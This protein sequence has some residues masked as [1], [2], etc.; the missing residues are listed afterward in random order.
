MAD[1]LAVRACADH[2]IPV[3][4]TSFDSAKV[5]SALASV[6]MDLTTAELTSLDAELSSGSHPTPATVASNYLKS[7]GL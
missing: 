6:D 3:I 2:L 4:R 7:K 5:T 1:R